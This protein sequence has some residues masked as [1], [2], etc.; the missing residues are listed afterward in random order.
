MKWYNRPDSTV[1]TTWT[2]FRECNRAVLWGMKRGVHPYKHNKYVMFVVWRVKEKRTAFYSH[3]TAVDG[4]ASFHPCSV[5]IYVCARASENYGICLETFCWSFKQ[6]KRRHEMKEG[7]FY[8]EDEE[9][10]HGRWAQ[11]S[12]K[13]LLSVEDKELETKKETR[14]QMP[15]RYPSHVILESFLSNF[16]CMFFVGVWWNHEEKRRRETDW[17]A[18]QICK[19]DVPISTRD[20][21]KK[22]NEW[23]IY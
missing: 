5:C 20:T 19:I 10:Q 7:D 2:G 8:S 1:Y 16:P 13:Q 11:W 17:N 12:Q 6:T 23:R 22:M 18:V 14:F 15:A 21:T 3:H 9:P 4:P